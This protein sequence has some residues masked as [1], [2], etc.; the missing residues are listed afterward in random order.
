MRTADLE[1]ELTK[2]QEETDRADKEAK[3]YYVSGRIM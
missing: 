1:G 2:G 3:T